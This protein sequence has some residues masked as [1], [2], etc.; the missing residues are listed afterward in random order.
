[1]LLHATCVALADR[2]LLIRGPSG[3]GKSALALMLMALGCELVAD[4]RVL[5][6]REGESLRAK[7]PDTIKGSIEAR[8]VGILNAPDARETTEL[9]AVVDLS[10][11]ETERL[12]PH[13]EVQV[14]GL[15]LP[16]LHGTPAPHFPSAVLQFLKAGRNDQV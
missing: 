8:S 7:A 10:Q 12:P 3:S 2:G 5:L 14:L 11:V 9:C 6:W 13:R 16:L 15:T 1:V 4:D